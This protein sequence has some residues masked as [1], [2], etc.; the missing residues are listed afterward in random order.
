M[1]G[2]DPGYCGLSEGYEGVGRGV[3]AESRCGA[4]E[5]QRWEG[6]GE[7]PQAVVDC[8]L[9]TVLGWRLWV[10]HDASLRRSL[11]SERGREGP[12]FAAVV[13]REI[14]EVWSEC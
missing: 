7:M 8:Q 12:L 3:C 11:S 14:A 2:G 5:L 1:G 10:S 6:W 13:R 9:A 4:R